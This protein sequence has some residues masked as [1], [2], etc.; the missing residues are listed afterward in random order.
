M[1]KTSIDWLPDLRLND[2]RT[3]GDTMGTRYTARFHAP[4]GADLR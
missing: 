3:C 4:P 2:C 1:S